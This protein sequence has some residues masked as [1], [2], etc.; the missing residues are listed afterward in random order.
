MVHFFVTSFTQ[1]GLLLVLICWTSS[2]TGATF[3]LE[4]EF[5]QL[6]E[7]YVRK[8]KFRFHATL[9]FLTVRD[10]ICNFIYVS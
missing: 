9:L 1:M 8:S 3:S 4:E 7:N 5:R 2:S 10:S 6:K